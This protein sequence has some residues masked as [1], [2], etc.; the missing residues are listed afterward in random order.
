MK[1]SGI[2]ADRGVD[3]ERAFETAGAAKEVEMR[4]DQAGRHFEFSAQAGGVRKMSFSRRLFKEMSF[5]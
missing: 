1:I 5:E 2:P 4:I 3:G